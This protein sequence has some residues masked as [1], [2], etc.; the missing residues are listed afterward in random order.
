[1]PNLTSFVA[2]TYVRDL[3]RSR[4]FYQ[5]LG[6][7]EQRAGRNGLS[8]WCY[9]RHGDYYVLVATSRP[10]IEIPPLPL[11]FYFFVD[12]L[13]VATEAMEAIGF[14]VEHL[15]YPPHALGGE[16]KTL[17]PDG[18]T[19]LLGQAERLPDQPDD[20]A[21]VSREFSLLREAASLA[22]HRAGAGRTCEVLTTQGSCAEPAEVKLAD[23]WGDTMWACLRHAEDAL[24][25]APAAFIADQSSDGLAAFLSAQRRR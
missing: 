22:Q 17:D 8:A 13:A 10:P 18:N 9:L 3:D 2:S 14:P 19:V 16:T 5:A 25:S 4:A 15:G 6:F 1:M 23:S 11:L 7:V 20:P 24:I 21:P 12:N